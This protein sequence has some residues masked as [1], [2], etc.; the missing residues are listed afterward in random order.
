MTAMGGCLNS[1]RKEPTVRRN[2]W[3]SVL[4]STMIAASPIIGALIVARAS[5]ADSQTSSTSPQLLLSIIQSPT[6]SDNQR[7]IA[8]VDLINLDSDNAR[9]LAREILVTSADPNGRIAIAR[10]IAAS[11]HP[12][13]IYIPALGSMLG[14]NLKQTKS[15]AAA[16][17]NYGRDPAAFGQLKSF[18]DAPN[19]PTD[20]RVEAVHAMGMLIDKEPAQYL[21]DLVSQANQPQ[22]LRDAAAAALSQMTGHTEFG[23]NATQWEQWWASARALNLRD[24]HGLLMEGRAREAAAFQQLQSAFTDLLNNDYYSAP[25]DARKAELVLKYLNSDSPIVRLAVVELVNQ[26]LENHPPTAEVKD[27]LVQMIADADEKVRLGV[28]DLIGASTKLK[29]APQLLPKLTERL[30]VEKN[31]QVKIHILQ[32]LGKFGLSA[33]AKAVVALLSDPDIDVKVAAATA[34]SGNLGTNFRHDDPAEAAAAQA[35]VKAFVDDINEPEQLRAACVSALVALQGP[36]ASEELVRRAV[37]GEPPEVRKAAL[38]GLGTLGNPRTNDVVFSIFNDNTRD[39]SI[40]LEAARALRSVAR[41]EDAHRIFDKMKSDLDP[42]VR[43]ALWQALYKLYDQLPPDDLISYADIFNRPP[44]KDPDKRL[45]TLLKLGDA[46]NAKHDSENYARNLQDVAQA[47]MEVTPPQS[48]EAIKD[49][50]QAIKY[51]REDSGKD[52]PSLVGTLIGDLLDDLLKSGQY[53]EAAKFAAEQIAIKPE[54]QQNVGPRI[55]NKA[56]ELSRSD[57]AGA[58]TLIDEALKMSPP[59]DQ[60][61]VGQLHQI[62]DQMNRQHP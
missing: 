35:Q 23:A 50:R 41:H 11:S 33:G 56:D 44:D 14:S 38:Q 51:W 25:T 12:D 30:L 32:A 52:M 43:Q 24:F 1:T 61:Y 21:V 31:P 62:Q 46:Y 2:P 29:D 49:L 27:R 53:A 26:N 40:R 22:T 4:A 18:V 15:A 6:T 59:L 16:L 57:P 45:A 3:I 5:A 17:A 55:K 58:K 42:A 9:K 48:A 13:P 39:P 54:Y 36:D 20:L 8:A 34:L 37:S 60:K 28:V 47:M 7:L 10:A 19:N